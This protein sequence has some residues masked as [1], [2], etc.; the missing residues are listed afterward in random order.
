MKKASSC[1]FVGGIHGVGKSSL[2]SVCAKELKIAHYVA[3]ELI[4]G[5]SNADRLLHKEVK[6]LAGNQDAL[7][8]A[9]ALRVR[10]EFYLLDGHFVIRV[11]GKGISPVPMST[12]MS[13]RPKAIVIVK[14]DP[15]LASHRIYQRD[16]KVIPPD[17]LDEMQR[18]EISEAMRVSDE[19]NCS[20]SILESPHQEG[21][22]STISSLVL[23]LVTGG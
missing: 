8:E 19:L 7:I 10:E 21:F 1:I 3:S 13:L 4:R 16:G 15:T 23:G 2:C 6:N 11:E 17:L 12:F 14:G 18:L 22:R 9:I 20:I 5:V